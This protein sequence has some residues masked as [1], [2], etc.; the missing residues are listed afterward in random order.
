[1]RGWFWHRHPIFAQALDVECDRFRNQRASFRQVRS[2]GKTT[3]QIA[4]ELH[5]SPTTI[6][7]YRTRILM[8]LDMKTTAQL[9]HYAI[10]CGLAD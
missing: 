9:I 4:W 3:R 8:K 7:T 6:S 1:M 5:L 10:G 2:N